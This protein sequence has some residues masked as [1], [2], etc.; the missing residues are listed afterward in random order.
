MGMHNRGAVKGAGP[1]EKGFQGPL[2]AINRGVD[3]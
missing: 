2:A 1:L 3:D